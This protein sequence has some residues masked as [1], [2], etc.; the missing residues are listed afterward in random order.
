MK[1]LDNITSYDLI[2]CFHKRRDIY[3]YQVMLR[4]AILY[5]YVYTN[6]SR[7]LFYELVILPF[8]CWTSV[9]RYTLLS[10]RNQGNIEAGFLYQKEI[11]TRFL[12]P[13]H[14]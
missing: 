13:N 11:I 5:G 1:H 2:T 7:F 12:S 10:T 9:A 3:F 14:W 4:V 8:Q 6:C